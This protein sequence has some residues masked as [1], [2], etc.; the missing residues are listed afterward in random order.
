MWCLIYVC[1]WCGSLEQRQG[2]EE[3]KRAGQKARHPGGENEAALQWR[4]TLPLYTSTETNRSRQSETERERERKS[5]LVIFVWYNWWKIS[6]AIWKIRSFSNAHVWKWVAYI[7]SDCIILI[8]IHNLNFYCTMQSKMQAILS[9][10]CSSTSNN[11]NETLL[12][13]LL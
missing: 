12:L 8:T 7:M 2:E 6:T 4:E 11:S 3:Q 1:F 9:E 5:V 13:L 10:F